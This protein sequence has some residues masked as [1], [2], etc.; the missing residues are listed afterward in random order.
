MSLTDGS[1]TDTILCRDDKRRNQLFGNRAWNG[2]DYL[3]VADDQ[4]SLCL[5]FF[6]DFPEGLE[7]R[8]F[9]ITGG[10]RIRDVKVIATARHA[11]DDAELDDCLQL[12]LNH[13]GDFST[14][15]VC[16]IDVPGIDPRFACVD[17]S[18]K[19]NCPSEQDCGDANPCPPEAFAEPEINYLAK[20]YGSFR[21]LIFD[22][23]AL[24][25]PDWR[26]RHAADLGV[27]L[28]ELLAYVGDHLS[29]AQDAVATEAYL[30]TA[31]L[32]V[33]VRR[34]L[35]LIDYNLN[36]GCNARAFVTLS[37]D[38][39]FGFKQARDFYFITGMSGN[40][41]G[42]I[43]AGSYGIAKAADLA[44]VPESRYEVFEPVMMRE[45]EPFAF[46]AA[47]SLIYIYDWGDGECCLP[48]GTTAT[49][50]FDHGNED[51]SNADPRVKLNPGDFLILEEVR[52]ATTGNPA[53][54]DPAHRHVVRLTKV[55][56]GYD[57]LLRNVIIEV[58][59]A[60]EDALPFALCISA[61]RASPDCDRITGISV[62]RGNVVLVDHGQSRT[63]DLGQVPTRD[64]PGDCACEGSFI[65]VR[66]V[67]L[68][69]T[70]V[71]E[72][73]PLVY[74]EPVALNAPAAVLLKRDPRAALPAIVLRERESSWRA[75]PE[76]MASGTEDS[77]FVAEVTDDGRAK[78]RFGNG[79]HGQQ[80]EPGGTFTATWRRGGSTAGN[81][82]REAISLLVVRNGSISTEKLSIRNPLPASG[83]TAPEA[84]DEARLIAPGMIRAR[85]ERAVVAEDYA[86][87]AQR[88]TRLQGA[89]ATLRWTGSWHEVHVAIDP[90]QAE[91]DTLSLIEEVSGALHRYR[92]IGHDLA[93]VP[94]RYVPLQL[95]LEVCVRAHFQRM[96]VQ[97][98]LRD[99]LG[100]RQLVNGTI[101][102][103]H[104]D[105]W[106]F[107]QSVYLSKIVAAAMTVE[108]VETVVV[109][110]LRRLDQP[111]DKSALDS[112][113]LL[114]RPGEIA[115]LGNDPDFP[116]HGQLKL[117]MGGGR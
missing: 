13:A 94:G 109:R 102:Y 98:A 56:T 105:N 111:L 72:S 61:R 62:A 89:A 99:L 4:R 33:S 39:D 8:H 68:S 85:R 107:G 88:N 59:W 21:Q 74:A 63:S 42:T 57:A 45:D 34:H 12:I 84:V 60:R 75:V 10:R 117:K 91:E 79:V 26:E 58:E 9:Q 65:E 41:I 100:N 52:G 55:T 93:V 54:A 104:A 86:E 90:V 28:V 50:L 16:L 83:G 11:T 37:T 53:D 112:G 36:E 15:T 46:F 69:F 35:R 51:N 110:D 71:L 92:R 3:D 31:R 66:R 116:E 24:V 108:G 7:P 64:V 96:Q 113:R 25:M 27:T 14:Y 38:A 81:V 80:P 77:H 76:L 48:K 40:D 106:R 47:N 43:Q 115:Q 70:P 87:L 101:G 1:Q 23:L 49:T 29:Y 30:D 5:H 82:G 32:R 44:R 2:L 19:N 6:S 78:L 114:I 95:T 97:A 17:F 20:D 103:F 18:F 22:R 67:P 73:G